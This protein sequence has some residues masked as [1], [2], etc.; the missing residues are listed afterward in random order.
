MTTYS[1]DKI[2]TLILNHQQ[3]EAEYRK[4]HEQGIEVPYFLSIQNG[5]QF[6]Y[7]L[8]T[9]HSHS[10]HHTQNQII[11]SRWDEFLQV[12]VKGQSVVMV[13]GG[14]R[15]TAKSPQIAIASDGEP[16]LAT[17]LAAQQHIE[18]ISPEPSYADQMEFLLLQFS[19]DDIAYYFFARE[20]WQW[21]RLGR[22]PALEVM[23]Q[24]FTTKYQQRTNWG[25]YDFSLGHMA[26]L[27]DQSHDHRFSPDDLDCFK[28]S[29]NPDQSPVPDALSTYRDQSVVQAIYN[30]WQKGYSIF[31]VYGAGHFVTQKSALE[32]L[33]KP[34]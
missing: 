8:G 32:T 24:Q 31:V 22:Q 30:R 21:H 3:T 10:P 13:E 28:I 12:T 16:G 2:H 20:M 33:L 4:M 6:L 17:F 1:S 27:H 11:Q 15:P 5:S 7:Y 26:S 9:A 25:D 34:V 19:Q 29:S 18:A 14:V 23:M